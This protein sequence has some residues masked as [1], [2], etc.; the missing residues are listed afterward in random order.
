[1][2]KRRPPK[3]KSKSTKV[4]DLS[5]YR[6]Q[7]TEEKRR[8]YERVLFNRVLGVY[9]FAEKAGLHHVEVVDM[10]FSGLKFV[11]EKPDPPLQVGQKIALRFY[12]TPSTYLRLVVEVKRVVPLVD[13]KKRGLE[14]G[15]ELDKS[16]RSYEV[17][18]QLIQ[19]MYK[20]SEVACQDENPPMIWF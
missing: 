8:E 14:Y 16:T 7:K 10:S 4:V 17:I 9:S 3:E 13:G 12:F 15:C 6:K 18:R 5:D 1:M 19:F 20:Y 11:E 2:E